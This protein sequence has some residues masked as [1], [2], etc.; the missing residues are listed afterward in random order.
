MPPPCTDE[1]KDDDDIDLDFDT[2][3]Q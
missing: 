2:R 1:F 3:C